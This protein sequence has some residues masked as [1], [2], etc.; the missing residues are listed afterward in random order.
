MFYEVKVLVKADDNVVARRKVAEALSFDSDF[1]AVTDVN[2]TQWQPVEIY[3]P[4]PVIDA[5]N[6]A[7]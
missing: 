7:S 5:L 1:L 2:S 3:K 4:N 6:R